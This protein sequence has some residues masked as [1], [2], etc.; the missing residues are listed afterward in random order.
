MG[1][2]PMQGLYLHWTEHHRM[3][4][5]HSHASSGIRNHDSSIQATNT[6]A[7]DRAA[8]VIPVNYNLL[9]YVLGKNFL[10]EIK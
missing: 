8:T 9:L 4:G 5:K 6:H 2:S 10:R 7:L 1:I 3:T